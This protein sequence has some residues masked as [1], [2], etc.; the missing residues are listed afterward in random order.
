MRTS[1]KL[2]L[3]GRGRS[4]SGSVKKG[5][6]IL[7]DGSEALVDPVRRL[8]PGDPLYDEEDLENYVLVSGDMDGGQGSYDPDA[9]RI[10]IGP[11]FTLSEFKRQLVTTVE[12]YF[13]SEDLGE[14]L[15]SIKEFGCPEY[16]FEVV[17]RTI[18]LS[19][20]RNEREREV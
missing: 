6:S 10:V 2:Q 7:N 8:D 1:S 13:V 16:H 19:L 17:K 12:E 3:K 14:A 5:D 11:Q 9:K 4:G 15:A 20:D 18:S